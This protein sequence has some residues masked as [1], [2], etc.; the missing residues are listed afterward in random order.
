[1]ENKYKEIEIYAGQSI[2]SVINELKKQS[3]LSCASFNGKMLYS[4]IDDVDSAYV[5]ITGI[6][7]SEFDAKLKA[8]HERHLEE[9]KIYK[10]SIPQLTE[11]WIEKGEKILDEKYMDLWIKCVPIRLND[12]YHGFELGCCL[13]IV[14]VLNESGDFKKAKDIFEEQGHSGMSFGLVCSMLK[15]FCDKGNA[16]VNYV[17]L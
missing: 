12:L 14:S 5:K 10:D 8:E 11:E 7:K 13:D 17:K 9:E 3:V 6:N 4:D 1:M 15:S 2:E 16:F